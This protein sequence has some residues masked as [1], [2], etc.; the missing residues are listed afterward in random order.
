MSLVNQMLRDLDA[1]QASRK[2]RAGLPPRLRPLPPAK[3]TR[4]QSLRM[5]LIGMALGS[6]IAGALVGLAM[7]LLRPPPAPVEPPLSVTPPVAL[8][9]PVQPAAVAP[10]TPPATSQATAPEVQ[11][12]PAAPP[13]ALPAAVAVTVPPVAAVR[14]HTPPASVAATPARAETRSPPPK[15]SVNVAKP[16]QDASRPTSPASVERKPAAQEKSAASPPSGAAPGDKP[17]RPDPGGNLTEAEY[18][19]GM[20]AANAG[21]QAA[22]LP[23]FQNALRI[24]P[25]NAQARQAL[26]SLLVSSRRLSEA[27]QVAQAGL[28]LDPTRSGWAMILTRLQHEQGDTEGA[29]RTL[30]THLP[31]ATGDA[32]YLALYAFLLQRQQRYIEAARQ[33]RQALALRPGEGRWWYGLGLALGA[34]GKEDEAK[35]AFGKAREVGNLPADMRAIVE[36]KLK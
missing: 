28:A 34:N 2:D 20:Q 29:L 19:K 22:A 32:D 8:P 17:A 12:A 21:D 15:P 25:R 26:L 33:Y 3:L 9:V 35:V 27:I 6:I 1:R 5:L 13:S 11:P 14:A 31:Y 7:S 16:I 10:Q 18:L 36:D 24:D 30:E 4:R 23:L